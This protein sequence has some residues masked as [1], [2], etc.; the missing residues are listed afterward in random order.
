MLKGFIIF[1][2]ATACPVNWSLAELHPKPQQV[3]LQAYTRV[4]HT[5]PAQ[6]RPCPPVVGRCIWLTSA[7]TKARIG[8][9]CSIP[10]GDFECGAKDLGTHE[11]C[12]GDESV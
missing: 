6:R 4:I 7:L 9:A 3:Y 10:A 8:T 11:L 12:H 1:F 5:K 2:T